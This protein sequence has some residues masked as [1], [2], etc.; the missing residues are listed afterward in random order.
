MSETI[1]MSRGRFERLFPECRRIIHALRR[2]CLF[3]ESDFDD[4][5]QEMAIALLQCDEGTDSLCLARAGWA[6]LDWL[7]KTYSA[8]LLGQIITMPLE[9][10][11]KIIDSDR[12]RLVWA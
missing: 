2:R 10:L 7:R 3:P 9:E 12:Y 5:E 4:M 11:I 8:R 6:A 1:R